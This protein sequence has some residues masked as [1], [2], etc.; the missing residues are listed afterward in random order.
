[1]T[2]GRRRSRTSPR[3]RG[4]AAPAFIPTHR[5][6]QAAIRV[7][8]FGISGLLAAAASRQLWQR[9][10]S[11]ST[12][13]PVARL[14]AELLDPRAGMSVYDP[15]FGAGRLLRAME[16]HARIRSGD[17]RAATAL[18]IFGRELDPIAFSVG[19]ATL[20]AARINATIALGDSLRSAP[21]SLL[22]G[23]SNGFDR[24]V[25]NPTWEQAAPVLP[26]LENE[27]L[28]PYGTPPGDSSDWAW[29]QHGLCALAPDGRMA[30]VLD[31]GALHRESERAIRA[32]IVQANLLD[33]V[34]T[35]ESPYRGGSPSARIMASF[36]E[37][38]VI[39][40]FDRQ[41][42][43]NGQGRSTVFIDVGELVV[44]HPLDFGRLV[45]EVIHLNRHRVPERGVAGTASPDE[46]AM[47]SYDLRPRFFV[48][49]GSRPH[50]REQHDQ[51]S[52]RSPDDLANK[53]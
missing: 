45:H 49:H 37:R 18:Q 43:Q 27:L 15:G 5:T 26:P 12:V 22:S 9:V 8:T 4:P 17:N 10:V 42:G 14:L 31:A 1:M 48:S 52:V 36:L 24:V 40:V 3:T 53:R 33:A 25:L 21:H 34:I 50:H 2:I 6:P 20:A 44:D 46:I 23:T 11:M 32:A 7:G 13:P 35:C 29:V 16:Q 41:N 47:R 28:F 39:L 19:A 51:E 30:V 38:A